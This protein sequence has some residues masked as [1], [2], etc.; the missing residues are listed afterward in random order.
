MKFATASI[1]LVILGGV[2][3]LGAALTGMALAS[4]PR[5]TTSGYRG[6]PSA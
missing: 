5:P 1:R 4:G 2:I 3:L 6:N